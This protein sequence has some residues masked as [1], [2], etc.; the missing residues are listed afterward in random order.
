MYL[1][2]SGHQNLKKIFPE[3]SPPPEPPKGSKV[4]IC[5]RGNVSGEFRS[6]KPEKGAPG[7]LS[8][9][10]ASKRLKS[11]H[12]YKE[13]CIWGVQVIKTWKRSSRRGLPHQGPQ[14]SKVAIC[15][16]GNVSGELRS[17][18]PEKG[19]PGEIPLTRA[20]KRIK[21]SHLCKGERIWGIQATKT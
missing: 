5:T 9:T 4:A 19:T 8:P 18:K 17:P 10:R 2:S 14:N 21:S 13:E 16:R 15:R 20:P 7:G 11:S 6:P 12:L 3:E 1:G